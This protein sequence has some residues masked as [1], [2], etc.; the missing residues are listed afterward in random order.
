MRD[1][2]RLVAFLVWY[3]CVVTQVF[4]FSFAD[5]QQHEYEKI[6]EPEVEV[7]SETF[8]GPY[9]ANFFQNPSPETESSFLNRQVLWWFNSVC[10]KGIRKPLE[11]PDLYSLNPDDSS[12][13]LVPK[14]N[15][16]WSKAMRG[17]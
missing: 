17:T 10:M 15:K 1:L 14:W 7:C 4:L 6:G 5:K 13:V 3:V 12:A 16:L 11:V 9:L 2:P 8:S